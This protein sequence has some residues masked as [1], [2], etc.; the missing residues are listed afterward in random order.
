MTTT[1]TGY[2]YYPLFKIISNPITQ[3]KLSYLLWLHQY[4]PASAQY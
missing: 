4:C 3:E 1:I 2:H